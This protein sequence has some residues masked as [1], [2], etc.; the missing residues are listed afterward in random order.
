[1]VTVNAWL[2]P[3]QSDYCRLVRDATQGEAFTERQ[4][5]VAGA[6]L[7]ALT[8]LGLAVSVPYWKILGILAP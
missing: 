8:L 5:T 1:L 7:T 2:H 3:R 4:A 6:V